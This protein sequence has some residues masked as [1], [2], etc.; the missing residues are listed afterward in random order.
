MDPPAGWRR[1]PRAG[2]AAFRRGLRRARLRKIP[3]GAHDRRSFSR[4]QLCSPFRCRTVLERSRFRR[5]IMT[6]GRESGRIF[7]AGLPADA[8]SIRSLFLEAKLTP[9]AAADL[10]RIRPALPG[11]ISTFVSEQGG[12]LVAVLGWRSLGEEAEILDLAVH[13]SHR[14][15]GHASFLMENF[16]AHVAQSAVQGI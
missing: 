12:L 2:R 15:Q 5:K 4:R 11:A 7:R 3:R 1:P 13:P 8:P 14:R 16:L 10:E 6:A 9:P